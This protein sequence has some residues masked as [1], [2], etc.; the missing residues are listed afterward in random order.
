MGSR[1]Y[2]IFLETIVNTDY[3]SPITIGEERGMVQCPYIRF[4]NFS[5]KDGL[6]TL[7]VD[8]FC[9]PEVFGYAGEPFVH[10]SLLKMMSVRPRRLPW[11]PIHFV[12]SVCD[13]QKCPHSSFL[14][15]EDTEMREFYDYVSRGLWSQLYGDLW[16]YTDNVPS[17]TDISFL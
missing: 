13:W 5:S 15:R 7:L 9:Y 3:F 11:E 1:L 10:T 8:M 4:N 2:E 6:P 14:H 12:Y 17:L 16:K